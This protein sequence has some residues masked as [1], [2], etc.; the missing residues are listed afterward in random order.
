[1]DAPFIV[2][3]R[4]CLLL[5]TLGVLYAFALA[6]KDFILTRKGA[7]NWL[8]TGV[9]ILAAGATLTNVNNLWDTIAGH[10]ETPSV[11]GLA[12]LILGYFLCF[13]AW[14]SA[15][16]DVPI[17]RASALLGCVVFVISIATYVIS[18]AVL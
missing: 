12:V 4:V 8:A 5:G 17:K 3:L 15:R 18:S 6:V 9:W 13:A 16:Y 7:D 1:M 10:S 14:W 11:I 2:A